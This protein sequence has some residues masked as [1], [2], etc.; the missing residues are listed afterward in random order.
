MSATEKDLRQ[1]RGVKLILLQWKQYT[2]SDDT[3]N[4]A[5]TVLAAQVQMTSSNAKHF[6]SSFHPSTSNAADDISNV[7]FSMKYLQSTLYTLITSTHKTSETLLH[8]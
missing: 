4:Q 8:V 6:K 5:V 2:D 7:L 1:H 3:N